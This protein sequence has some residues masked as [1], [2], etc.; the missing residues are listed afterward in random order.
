MSYNAAMKRW[1]KR[2]G[3]LV[4]ILIALPVLFV[5]SGFLLPAEIELELEHRLDAT[6]EALYELITTYDGV[7][8]WWN[9][10]NEDMGEEF[11][12][13]H[14]GGPESGVGMHLGFAYPDDDAFEQWTFASVEAPSTIQMDVDFMSVF[15]SRRTLELTPDGQGTLV[16]W[17]ETGRV[18]SPLWRWMLRLFKSSAI[19]NRH[20]VLDSAGT[21]ANRNR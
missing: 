9:Q 14:L 12:V 11:D 1:L 5:L 6:P 20:A 8:N 13:R 2:L 3:L 7:R 18:D 10:A 17:S 16:H 21:V 19:D 15:I 4:S